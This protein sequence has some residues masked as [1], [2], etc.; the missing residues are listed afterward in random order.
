MYTR[1]SWPVGKSRIMSINVWEYNELCRGKVTSPGEIGRDHYFSRKIWASAI[2]PWAAA[3]SHAQGCSLSQEAHTTGRAGY[4][5]SPLMTLHGETEREREQIQC[6]YVMCVCNVCMC[7]HYAPHTNT[8]NLSFSLHFLALQ[9][10]QQ[11]LHL[12]ALVDAWRGYIYVLRSM[13]QLSCAD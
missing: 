3:G 7:T 9:W 5:Q 1:N 12:Q 10:W 13:G 2:P 11:P 4:T 8:D 6:V